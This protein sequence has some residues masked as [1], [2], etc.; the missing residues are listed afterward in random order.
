MLK[1]YINLWIPWIWDLFDLAPINTRFWGW[2]RIRQ[3]TTSQDAQ[4]LTKLE[5]WAKPFG[6]VIQQFNETI[7]SQPEDYSILTTSEPKLVQKSRPQLISS[8]EVTE[9]K[10]YGKKGIMAVT[11]YAPYFFMQATV[12]NNQTRPS[13]IRFG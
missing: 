13:L 1:V 4:I 6:E 2:A 3:G 8:L 12:S 7:Q 11:D 5:F 9:G 10:E